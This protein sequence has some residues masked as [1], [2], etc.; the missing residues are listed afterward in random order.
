MGFS[1]DPVWLL[2][3]MLAFG[4]AMGF[5]LVAFPF[6]LPSVPLTAR[7]AI[8]VAFGIGTE[9]LIAH[10]VAIPSTGYGFVEA[11]G[12][13]F[14]VGALLGYLAMLFVSVGE[15]AGAMVGLFGGFSPPPALDPLS[16]NE[17]P[18]TGQ[19]YGLIWVVLFFVSG[20]DIA[21][22]HGYVASF[23]MASLDHLSFG[24]GLIV[25]AVTILFISSLEIASPVLA[26]MFFSQVVSGVL[27]KVAPQL[28]AL[29]FIFPLQILL[30]LILMTLS[31]TLLPHL[32]DGSMRALLAGERDLLR[33]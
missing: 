7:V 8:A 17:T 11:F 1:V 24:L 32:F 19:F 10:N 15:S 20:A 9:T 33:G 4:R 16:L 5:V 14:V 2:A 23:S 22:V 29:T 21:V 12:L 28:N 30:S 25:R 31:V 3:Y 18:L 13:Q 26:V 6:A 27:V